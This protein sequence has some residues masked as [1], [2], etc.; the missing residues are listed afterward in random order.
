LNDC[1]AELDPTNVRN[2]AA[3]LNVGT[4]S[5]GAN[6]KIELLARNLTFKDSTNQVAV[7]LPVAAACNVP[8]ADIERL[9]KRSFISQ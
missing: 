7:Q 1:N 6:W 2:A 8:C 4:W 5:T 3:N 9:K